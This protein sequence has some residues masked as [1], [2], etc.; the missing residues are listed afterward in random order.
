[1]LNKL[2]ITIK[3]LLYWIFLPFFAISMVNIFTTSIPHFPVATIL[4][5]F[6]IFWSTMASAYLILDGRGS[7]F[8]GKKV[9]PKRLVKSGP[10]SM[11]RHPIYFG[12]IIYTLGLTLWINLFS[13]W[14][15]AIVVI[16]LTFLALYE[17]RKLSKKFSEYKDY[18]KNVP[19]FLLPLKKWKIDPLLNPPFLYAF[20]FL[21]GKFIMP[22]FYDVRIRGR[23]KVPDGPY[24]PISSHTS[25]IDPLFMIDAL[26]AY[27]RFP[28][29]TAHQ[30]KAR[31]FFDHTGIFPIKRYMV[32]VSA[33]MKFTKTMKSGGIIGIFPEG[34]RNWDG[35]PLK[36][37][38]GVIKL[39]MM[40]PN[41]ILPIRIK[42]A[43]TF[44]PRWAKK[45]QKG[46]IEVEIGDP[47]RPEDCQKAFDFIFEGTL[48]E[49][50]HYRDYRGI[51]RYI[52][53]CPKCDEIGTIR[54]KKSGFECVKCHAQWI[55]PSIA[56]VRNMHDNFKFLADQA[57]S[58]KAIVNGEKVLIRID[59]PRVQ[60]GNDVFD[61]KEIQSVLTES[62]TEL[63]IYTDKLFV[64]HFLHTSPLMWKEYFNLL[65]SSGK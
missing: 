10:Y 24:V 18:K 27:I 5:A 51:E 2:T 31:W 19:F 33:M 53:M 47:V 48:E 35:R 55:K 57:I 42:Y 7:P 21:I 9:S 40:S 13:L 4:V 15:W 50:A 12:Y 56:D 54:S 28:I 52:Y 39:L 46:I 34:E 16:V 6:G 43:H 17:E 44:W 63:Y 20:L 30:G 62:N 26:N 58:D 11:S 64:I 22:F 36:I 25:Y 41:P 59:I 23:E 29:T 37:Q 60:I 8:F 38:E 1:M 14:I 65:L 61:L 45:L 3:I 32:D 49:N